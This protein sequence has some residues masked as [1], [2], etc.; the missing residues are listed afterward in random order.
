MIYL[1]GWSVPKVNRDQ[2]T[3]YFGLVSDFL[4]S[5]W[6]Y[7][8]SQSRINKLP[9]RI[10]VGGALSGRD[11]SAMQKTMS[12]LLKLMFPDPEDDIP[13]DAIQF[14]AFDACKSAAATGSS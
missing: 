12:G 13:D 2:L 5:C 1:P 14:R 8:S 3:E 10:L 11:T 4:P 9:G 7:L 6:N